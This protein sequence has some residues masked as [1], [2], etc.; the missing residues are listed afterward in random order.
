MK[1]TNEHLITRS[2]VLGFALGSLVGLLFTFAIHIRGGNI[3]A[4]YLIFGIGIVMWVC[5]EI[6]IK[7]KGNKQ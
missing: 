3:T 2:L 7:L 6:V 4:G 1:L 5:L